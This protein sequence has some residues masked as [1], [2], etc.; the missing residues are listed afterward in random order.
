M[1][2]TRLMI[3]AQACVASIALAQGDLLQAQALLMDVLNYLSIAA[4][5]GI[6][7]RDPIRVYLTCY[8]TARQPGPRAGDVLIALTSLQARAAKTGNEV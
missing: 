3:E 2:E 6:G 4:L 5:D 8:R 1:G 7:I